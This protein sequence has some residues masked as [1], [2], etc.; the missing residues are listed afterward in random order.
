MQEKMRTMNG[1]EVGEIGDKKGRV[2]ERG[3]KK[4]MGK[5]RGNRMGVRGKTERE[6]RKEGNEKSGE[7][8]R[9][10]RRRRTR[11]TEN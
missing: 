4:V 10:I 5:E 3:K 6:G 9:E 2:E 7:Y 11:N 8:D 1:R